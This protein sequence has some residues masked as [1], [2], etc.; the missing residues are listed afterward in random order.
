MDKKRIFIFVPGLDKKSAKYSL[1][2]HEKIVE[3][4]SFSTVALIKL[5][6]RIHKKRK[7]DLV[8]AF[9]TKEVEKER[10]SEIE[11][12]FGELGV[13]VECIP[14]PNGRN[15][16]ELK[17]IIKSMLEK[18][19][20]A[21]YLTLDLT[22]GFRSC[23]IVF[24]V[25]VQYIQFLRKNIEIEGFYY[26]MIESKDNEGVL[27]S[28]IVDLKVY[29]DLMEWIYA[30]RVF[31]DTHQGMQIASLL[32][33]YSIEAGQGKVKS[34]RRNLID[35]SQAYDLACP[36]EIGLQARSLKRLLDMGLPERLTNE[37]PLAQELFGLIAKLVDK[38]KGDF[39]EKKQALLTTEELERQAYVIDSYIGFQQFVHVLGLIRE[40]MV[41]CV[42]YHNGMGD[43]WL[44]KTKRL[45]IEEKLNEMMKDEARDK[46]RE[47]LKNWE[48][49]CSLR[50]PI[51][52]HGFSDENPNISE[53]RIEKINCTWDSVKKRIKDRDYW[54]L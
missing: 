50:N 36:I 47:L 38:Y 22:H 20:A 39:N 24:S 2:D 44:Q 45:S 53:K 37:I 48:Y 6:E 25:A 13:K 34:I 7:P 32:Q 9:C 14:I 31:S 35:Y 46:E 1:S 42:M 52:H 18:I 10:W 43:E 51:Y 33:P 30:V 4:A 8:L 17:M 15:E 54:S 16:P 23:P 11:R 29:L 41:C 26:G 3:S 21:C 19:P 28:T 40:W 49:I 27:L 12:S 5:Q